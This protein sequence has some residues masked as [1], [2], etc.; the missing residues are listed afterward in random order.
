MWQTTLSSYPLR[1][2]LFWRPHT[3][4]HKRWKGNG[5]STPEHTRTS[6]AFYTCVCLFFVD[7]YF[8]P[9]FI[10]S[11]RVPTHPMLWG[12]FVSRDASRT[13]LPHSLDVSMCVYVKACLCVTAHGCKSHV[14]V[15]F[16]SSYF[17][18]RMQTQMLNDILALCLY[19][20]GWLAIVELR[21]QSIII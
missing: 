11:R 2:L 21:F 7:G 15:N 14:T 4:P 17:P 20:Y 6:S 19:R 13:P 1:L 12:L 9:L 16:M 10:T 5:K 18:F 8:W 3:H